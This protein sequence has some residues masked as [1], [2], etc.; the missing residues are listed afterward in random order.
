MNY[1]WVNHKQTYRQEVQGGYIWS[2][3]AKANGQANETYLTLTRVQPGDV[4]VSY[5]DGQIKALGVA[6]APHR[7][8]SKPEAFGATGD[9]WD[10]QG[11]LVPVEWALLRK[12]LRPKDHLG[13][14][15][16]LLPSK[17]SPIR[18]ET[19]DGNQGCYLASIS[20]NLGQLL[21]RL[22]SPSDS[23][24]LEALA[25]QAAQTSED[26]AEAQIATSGGSPTEVGQLVRARRGQG[27]F[28]LNVLAV[29]KRCRLTGVE[30]EP[31]LIASHIKPWAVASDE[32]RL[33]GNNGLV[34]APHADLL[35]DRG[36]ISFADDGSIL[37]ANE[38]AAA[39]LASW[40]LPGSDV[41]TAPFNAKQRE[42]LAFHRLNVFGKGF[43]LD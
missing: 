30:L 23:A 20:Q 40:A 34:L 1:W 42:Y 29:E 9:V 22:I 27:R 33:D 28:R 15:G 2:P 16:P 13:A 10:S 19:G 36:W 8:E 24:A 26:I 6:T 37:V 31:F 39:V 35:F 18:R 43:R 5:A 3:K 12:P 21:L 25:L 7:E 41:A 38:E 11:W 17:H 32:E 4:V 14:I